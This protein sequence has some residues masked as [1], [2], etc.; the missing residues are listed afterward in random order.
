MELSLPHTFHET[1]LFRKSFEQH[2]VSYLDLTARALVEHTISKL[3]TRIILQP[4]TSI[5]RG[6]ADVPVQ[7]LR[8]RLTLDTPAPTP[9]PFCIIGA[10]VAGL[11]AAM[12]LDELG[13]EYDILEANDRVGGRVLTHRFTSERYDYYDVGAMRFPDV[14]F[15]KSVFDLFKNIGISSLLVQIGRAHV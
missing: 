7:E 2:E 1:G 11:Y 14:P 3:S 10:G 9:G 13:I 5:H 8:E 12:L 6:R 4:P 15:M